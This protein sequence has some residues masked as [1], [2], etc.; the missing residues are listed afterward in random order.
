LSITR[1]L[2]A[3]GA[4]AAFIFAACAG[5][6]SSA[7]PTTGAA[8]GAPATAAPGS[9]AATSAAVDW[10]A[11]AAFDT[12]GLGDKSFNDLA[13][14]GL[15]DAAAAGYTTHEAEAST[16]TDYA[17]NLQRLIDQGCQTIIAVGFNY[18]GAVAEK[19]AANPTIAFAQVDTTWADGPGAG[20]DF[21]PGT[22]DDIPAPANY[23]GLDYQVDQAAMLAGYLAAG[24]SKSGKIGTYGGQP[25]AGVTRFMDGLVAGVN[26]YNSKHGTSASVLGWDAVKQEGSFVGGNN[27]WNDSATGEQRGLALLDQGV[28]IV[29]PV[30]GGT[31][32]A[33]IKAMFEAGKWAI[34]VD[35]DQYISLGPPTNAALL[36]SAQKNIDGSV[37]D[38]INKNA[39]GDLGGEDYS[40]TIRNGGVLIAPY[41]DLDS[42]IS[43]ELKAEIEELK[44]A[45]VDGTISVC[46]FSGLGC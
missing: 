23:T 34:G 22:A 12:G 40:G 1:R 21:T 3:L 10:V 37:L 4:S 28:D 13:Q 18:G 27:P 42:Q 8:T 35:T 43:A 11:C 20:K 19:A 5:T 39:E 2:L 7:A 33:T 31:G 41:H 16:A 32:N 46:D 30:A 45:L 24:F 44:A 9:P 38:V 36:T 17:A 14:K 15:K 6:G 25:F 29:L 26:Y